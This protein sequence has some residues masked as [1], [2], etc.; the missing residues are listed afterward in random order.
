MQ[1]RGVMIDCSRLM[2]R[3]EYYYRLV[4]FM[5]DWRMNTLVWHFTD[6]H[7]CAVRLPGFPRLA[8]RNAFT[9]AEMRRLI[10]HAAERG[11]DVI[12]ELETFGHTRYLTD[13]PEY[14]HLYAGRKRRRL[15]FN[16]VDP[17]SPAAHSLMRRL[18]LATAKVFPSDILHIGCDEVNLRDYC[19]SHG[20]LDE[21]AVWTDYVNR[22][23]DLARACGK[24][25]MLWGDHPTK[26]ARI[27]EM[28]RKDVILVDWR[29]RADVREAVL[30]K[31]KRVGFERIVVAPSIA[32]AGYRFLPTTTALTNTTK[33]ARMG[34]KHGA[35]GLINTIWCPYRYV[36][37][38]LSYGIAYTAALLE[39]GGRLDRRAFHQAFA[40]RVFGTPLTGP[41]ARFLASWPAL[42]ITQDLS[43]ELA[44][45]TPRFTPEQV[46]RLQRISRIG[47]QILPLAD[48]YRPEKNADIWRA[49]VLAGRA[50]WLCSESAMLRMIRRPGAE[51]T[52][53][54]NTLLREVRKTLS[55]VWDDTRYADDPQ[56][57]RTK[58][59]G[60]AHQYALILLRR[61]PLMGR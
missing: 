57:R 44:R 45:R 2:E 20:G 17:L 21:A 49:M 32:C 14:A 54:Y 46:E 53:A 55:Q 27:A 42:D 19:R 36:Q 51:R 5:A 58:F 39:N 56:K 34:F 35:D 24:T 1:I 6:D 7:G 40:G 38:A 48:R 8:V 43:R 61:L 10:A 60:T 52:N 9:A 3:H 12:P 18:M 41:L 59:P 4:D 25:P 37:G 33:M 28:L 15:T 29:Y 30:V 13:R 16:A 50:A 31:L 26:D 47:G 11:I 22:M 23:I